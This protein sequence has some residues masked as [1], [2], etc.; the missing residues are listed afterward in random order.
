MRAASG[1]LPAAGAPGRGEKRSV[2]E[3]MAVPERLNVIIKTGHKDI[4]IRDREQQRE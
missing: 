2:S 3:D 1:A 4:R